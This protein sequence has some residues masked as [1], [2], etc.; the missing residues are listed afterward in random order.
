MS[1]AE[2]TEATVEATAAE[3][4]TEANETHG[5]KK[6][7]KQVRARRVVQLLCSQFQ[8]AHA[9]DNSPLL[10]SGGMFLLQIVDR[11]GHSRVVSSHASL[12]KAIEHFGSRAYPAQSFQCG[13]FIS[14]VNA[15][16]VIS[17]VADTCMQW[18]DES[19]WG[20]ECLHKVS[21]VSALGSTLQSVGSLPKSAPDAEKDVEEGVAKDEDD[22]VWGIQQV[23]TEVSEKD[24]ENNGDNDDDDSGDDT[25][26][27]INE[28]D[29]WN[30]LCEMSVSDL[31]S[32]F[33]NNAAH[34]CRLIVTTTYVYATKTDTH[35]E[36]CTAYPHWIV[37]PL[38]RPVKVLSD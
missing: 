7:S 37:R 9:W 23:E 22:D 18:G 13:A 29:L 21:E 5:E 33:G 30:D 19:S 25:E 24:K 35:S 11:G 2:A 15:E 14:W 20:D 3:A 27:K 31:F 17:I 12:K 6:E 38:S 32:E 8:N 36:V 4:T 1:S 34:L 26:D 28:H 16:Q 10:P